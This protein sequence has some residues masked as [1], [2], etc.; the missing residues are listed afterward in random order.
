MNQPDDDVAKTLGLDQRSKI[1]SRLKPYLLWGGL[2]LAA[3]L[4]LAFWFGLQP[5]GQ[6]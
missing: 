4:A 2:A 3:V 6:A 1:M 5:N